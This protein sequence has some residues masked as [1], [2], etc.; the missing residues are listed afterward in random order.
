MTDL[1]SIDLLCSV[2]RDEPFVWPGLDAE[3]AGR[4]YDTARHHGVHLLVADRLWRRGRMD[5]CPAPLRD[6][7]A[8]SLRSQLAFEMIARRELQ[9][10]LAAWCMAGIHPLLFKG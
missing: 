1:A 7:L 8:A 6:R 5:S 10:L 4:L 2:L 9:A 3:A